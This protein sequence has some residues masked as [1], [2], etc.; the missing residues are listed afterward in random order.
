MEDKTKTQSQ[1]RGRSPEA[2]IRS[3]DAKIQKLQAEKE[4]ILK[5]AKIQKII[6]AATK[7][8]SVEEI[9]K[10]LEIEL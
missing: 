2:R 3:I 7:K 8:Y 5:T 9:A 6:E 1:K 4:Y 10:N